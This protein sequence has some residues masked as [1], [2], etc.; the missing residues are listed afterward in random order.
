[1]NFDKDSEGCNVKIVDLD[2]YN[3][4]SF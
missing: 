4:V 3:L 1:M 2:K